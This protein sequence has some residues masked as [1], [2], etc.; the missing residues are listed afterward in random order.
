M[1]KALVTFVLGLALLVAA[2]GGAE[3]TEPPAPTPVA[4]ATLIPAT[5]EALPSD[6][7][8]V[9]GLQDVRSATIRIQADGSF[10]D[11]DGNEY[12]SKSN[13]SGFIIDPEGIAVTNNHVVEGAAILHVWVGGESESRNARIVG[14]SECA[15]L[16]VIDIEGDGYPY[17]TWY[18]GEISPGLAVYAAGYPHGEPEYTLTQG[19]VT[20]AQADGESDWASVDSVLQ[21]QAPIAPGSSGGPLITE[22]GQVVAV[23]YASGEDALEFLAITG[24]QALPIIERLRADEDVDSIG[25]NPQAVT[26][27]DGLNGIWVTSVRSGSPADKTGLKAGDMIT[28]M[29]GMTFLTDETPDEYTMADY[30]DI[31]RTHGPEATIDIKVV[32]FD[33]EEVLEGQINGRPLEAAFSFADAGEDDVADAGESYSDYVLLKDDT[34]AIQLEVPAEWN[35]VDGR[36]LTRDDGTPLAASIIAAP[37]LDAYWDFQAPGIEFS[38]QPIIPGKL[39]IDQALEIF[40]YGDDCEYVG[41]EPYSDP[42]YEGAYDHYTNCSGTSSALFVVATFPEDETFVNIIVIKALTDA[43]L[44]AADYALATFSVVGDLPELGQGTDGDQPSDG[45]LVFT[46]GNRTPAAVCSIHMVPSDA[47]GWGE[48]WLGSGR[49]ESGAYWSQAVE[50]GT[51]YDLLVKDCSDAVLGVRWKMDKNMVVNFGATNESV[52]LLFQNQTDVEVCELYVSPSDSEDWGDDL[53][54][55]PDTVVTPDKAWRF[56][57]PPGTY[58]LLVRD[59]QGQDLE[60]V[61]EVDLT[62]NRTWTLGG[63]GQEGDQ[64]NGDKFTITVH[65][66]SP[67]PICSVAIVSAGSS[68]G[69]DNWLGSATLG[70]GQSKEF[71]V[72]A[73]SYDVWAEDCSNAYLGV[74]WAVD[75]PEVLTIGGSG[76]TSNLFVQNNL[77]ADVC[78]IKISPVDAEDWG[79]DWLQEEGATI[80]TGR[81]WRFW[82]EPGIYDILARDCDGED[83]ERVDDVDLNENRSWTLGEETQEGDQNLGADLYIWV[84]NDTP[85]PICSVTIAPTGSKEWGDNLLQSEPLKA[86]EATPFGVDAGTYDVAARD[87]DSAFLGTLWAVEEK[88]VL[89]LGGPG[90]TSSLLV[91]NNLDVSVCEVLIE[92]NETGKWEGNWLQEEG[93][94]ITPGTAWRFWVEPGEYIV[95][96]RDCDGNQLKLSTID[97]SQNRTWTLGGGQGGG[98]NEGSNFIITV[99]NDSHA[100]ICSVRI[101][102]SG[103]DDWGDNWLGSASLQAGQSK[104]FVVDAGTYDVAARDCSDAYLGVLWEVDKPEVLTIGGPGRTSNMV[105][106]NDLEIDVCEIKISP[107]DAEDWGDDWLQEEGAVITAGTAWRFWVEPGLHDILARDCD[108]EDLERVN[109]VDLAKNLRWVLRP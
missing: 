27:E 77:E 53:L 61:N 20:R 93:A 19:I 1:K 35:D 65:N 91:Q 108:G 14:V 100:P 92:P 33:T 45:S 51:T 59:C 87:C 90:R 94:A 60:Q 79:D 15:D 34:G 86:G 9:T 67:L 105:V 107:A 58:D 3:P 22:E 54:G 13:G 49:L 80:R 29:A 18:E 25:I 28:E 98:Q 23:N 89:T 43:D 85:Q 42:L 95:V 101:A 99:S 82:V 7:G 6:T 81:I 26:F 68:E 31:L 63:G 75:Q 12:S 24:P 56:W 32:R 16:A 102:P 5:T 8:Q 30:C 66:L 11:P 55:Q 69:G 4:A 109:D 40:D 64:G 17:L 73:G 10:Y 44:D 36:L 70:T 76:R 48:N 47:D 37:D 103:S 21:H 57:L 78:E 83:L 74:L 106:Q 72:D 52:N 96:A 104:E 38:S 41:R 50:G 62:Q 39:T 84:N 88:E 2:C 71:A 97:L 46:V